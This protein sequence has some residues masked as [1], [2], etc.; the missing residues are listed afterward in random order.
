MKSIKNNRLNRQIG[1]YNPP[2]LPKG[3]LYSSYSNRPHAPLIEAG[4]PRQLCFM[5]KW[6]ALVLSA[7]I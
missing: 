5:E 2:N 1:K 4:S 7:P 6:A 3:E